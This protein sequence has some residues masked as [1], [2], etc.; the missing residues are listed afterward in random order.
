VLLLSIALV[1]AHLLA[2]V[3]ALVIWRVRSAS[4][5]EWALTAAIAWVFVLVL[6]STG[7]WGVVGYPLRYAALL[8]MAVATFLS[9]RRAR[10]L[11]L[12]RGGGWQEWMALAFLA[13][14]VEGGCVMN[15]VAWRGRFPDRERV[16]LAFPLR[17]GTYHIGQ[18]GSSRALN[19]HL[20]IRAQQYALDINKLNRV[21]TIARGLLPRDLARYA[22]FGATVV[23]PCDGEIV[24][25]QNGLPDLIPPDTDRKNTKGNYIV[26]NCR[27]SEA[28]VLLAHLKRDSL[29]TGTGARVSRGQ[30]LANV[31]N[32]G[33][34]S[35]PHLHL[36]ATRNGEGIPMTFEGRFL[37]RNDLISVD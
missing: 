1:I 6:F 26:V 21:G 5:L 18:G 33:N 17:D 9:W 31:G 28:E 25:S 8:C 37:A 10:R 23:S 34:T 22:I 24:D 27:D 13:A 19:T 11:P 12:S 30:Q 16:E 35:H 7:A 20:P 4:R 3:A 14:P 15:V 36:Q 2:F 32:S 29:R